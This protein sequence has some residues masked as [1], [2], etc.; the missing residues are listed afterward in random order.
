MAA[1]AQRRVE[2][3]D[4]GQIAAVRPPAEVGTKAVGAE[5]R[6]LRP[7]ASAPAESLSPEDARRRQVLRYAQLVGMLHVRGVA[8]RSELSRVWR[9]GRASPERLAAPVSRIR[10][11]LGEA[12]L[13]AEQFAGYCPPMRARVDAIA[14]KVTKAAS[15]GTLDRLVR[16]EMFR[17]EAFEIERVTGVLLTSLCRARGAD[18]SRQV[19]PRLHALAGT[20]GSGSLAAESSTVCRRIP[21]LQAGCQEEAIEGIRA[22][23]RATR[24]DW[25]NFGQVQLEGAV[26]RAFPTDP[27]R[28]PESLTADT[29]VQIAPSMPR[30]RL[31][32]SRLSVGPETTY[33]AALAARG[34]GRDRG[35]ER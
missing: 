24:R 14:A 1:A 7:D 5:I 20:A 25:P 18:V 26:A 15:H 17:A 8:L 30:D 4:G 16:G 10:A 13:D 12:S 32:P 34:P 19:I 23:L 11:I 29:G 22:A 9:M 3:E 6:M 31:G 33:Q 2:M 35:Q 27:A 21:I 28:A